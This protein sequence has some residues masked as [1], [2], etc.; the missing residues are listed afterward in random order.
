[1]NEAPPPQR[2]WAWDDSW[3]ERLTQRLAQQGHATAGAFFAAHPRQTILELAQMLGPG[4]APVQLEWR[5]LDEAK[6]SGEA[7]IEKCAR[8]LLLR[9]VR[10]YMPDGWAPDDETADRH[11]YGGWASGVD[12]IT[13]VDSLTLWE[14]LAER[15]PA[16]W[17]PQ[18][19]NDPVLA[20]V[21]RQHWHNAKPPGRNDALA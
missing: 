12:R 20:D 13:E 19:I 18:D 11:A 4:V 8:D 1:M 6:A 14:A 16:G 3:Q 5:F 2:Q 15:A 21:F 17:L 10:R 9:N 7:E